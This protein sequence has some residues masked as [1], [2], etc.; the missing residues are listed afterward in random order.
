[1]ISSFIIDCFIT[2][3]SFIFQSGTFRNEAKM[4][5]PKV[6]RSTLKE[7]RI[8]EK[9]KTNLFYSNSAHNPYF[10]LTLRAQLGFNLEALVKLK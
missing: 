3:Q 9:M 5:T 2:N 4:A 1:M 8:K 10:T 6:K 7:K